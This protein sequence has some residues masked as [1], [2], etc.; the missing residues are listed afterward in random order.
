MPLFLELSVSK[1]KFYL[2]IGHQRN[3]GREVDMA[4]LTKVD[5][6]RIGPDKLNCLSKTEKKTNLKI[7][8][9][10]SKE[11]NRPSTAL[12]MP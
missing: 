4:V 2:M 1:N 12:E 5:M 7:K 3:P 10:E 9:S 6:G 11:E 8:E